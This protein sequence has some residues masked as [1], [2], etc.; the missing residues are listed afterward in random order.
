MNSRYWWHHMFQVGLFLAICLLPATG[1]QC[2]QPPKVEVAL[3]RDFSVNHVVEWRI[4]RVCSSNQ[5]C[6]GF[7]E[8]GLMALMVQLCPIQIQFGDTVTLSPPPAGSPYSMKAANVSY[9]HWLR[10]PP[11]NYPTD[12]RLYDKNSTGLPYEIPGR[13]LHPG[14]TYIAELENG[15]FSRCF[16]GLRVVVQIK[17]MDCPLGI[18]GTA[19]FNSSMLPDSAVPCSGR[20]VCGSTLLDDNYHCICRQPYTGKSLYT[21]VCSSMCIFL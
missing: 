7:M 16:Y 8:D 2:R 19:F 17:D 4:E 15:P 5:E 1:F 3:W 21:T 13:F 11:R 18:N 20:G 6:Y 10:C 9:E 12:Q 14:T